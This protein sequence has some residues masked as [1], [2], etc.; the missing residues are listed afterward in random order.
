MEWDLNLNYKG[1][2]FKQ[3]ATVE[4]SSRQIL[5]IRV[6]G[7]KGSLLLQNDYPAVRFAN[8]KKGVHWKIREGTL[9]AG[10]KDSAQLLVDI[11][12]QLEKAMKDDFDKIFPKELF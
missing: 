2:W 3:K 8:S 10:D 9:N 12:K 4:Y 6:D 1:K 5:R 11:F 7:K